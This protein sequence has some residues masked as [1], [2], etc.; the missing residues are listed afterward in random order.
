M[1]IPILMKSSEYAS[2]FTKYI[3]EK[4]SPIYNTV[5]EYTSPI[6]NAIIIADN[7]GVAKG[8]TQGLPSQLKGQ[9]K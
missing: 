5:N 3:H 8:L 6:T 7:L 4:V 1:A 2:K 9:L